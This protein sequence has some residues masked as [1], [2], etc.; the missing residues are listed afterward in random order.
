MDNVSK[1]PLDDEIP[2]LNVLGSSGGFEDG[3]NLPELK[4]RYS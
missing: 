3:A 1:T 4:S 2:F